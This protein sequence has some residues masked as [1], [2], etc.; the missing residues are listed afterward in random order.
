MTQK[1]EKKYTKAEVTKL[2]K[3]QIE[4][5][6]AQIV[7]DNLSKVTAKRKIGEAKLASEQ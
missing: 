5:C 2:L 1:T 4:I 7:D 6:Q 3:Q